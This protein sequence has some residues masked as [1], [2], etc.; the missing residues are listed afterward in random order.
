M[1]LLLLLLLC[2]APLSSMSQNAVGSWS[3]T[4]TTPAGNLKIV[5][6]ISQSDTIYS[7]TM[8]S[9][10]QRARD[11]PMK[12]TIVTDSVVTLRLGNIEYT[13]TLKRD[14]LRGT[15]TQGSF[16]TE[17]N[18]IRA[19]RPA[20]RPAEPKRPQE[21]K[22]PFDYDS[23]QVTFRNGDIELSGT[24][25]TP[26]GKG[27]SMAVVMVTGSGA[28]DRDEQI[29]G[30]KPFLVIADHLTRNG[31]SVLRYDDRGVGGSTGSM[32]NS[33]TSDFAIDVSCA[34]QFLKTQPEIDPRRIGII[35]NSEGGLIAPM[36]ASESSDV[37]F[38]VLL[39]APAMRGDKL[40]LLQKR[41]IEQA[42]GYNPIQVELSS[43]LMAGAFALINANAEPIT[44]SLTTYF[45][46]KIPTPQLKGIVAQLSST[47]FV[48][49]VRTDPAPYLSRVKCPILALN[50]GK[51]LQVPPTE[52]ITLIKEITSKAGNSNVTTHIMPKL[53]HL[54]QECTTGLPSE[55]AQIEQT[56]HPSVL[57]TMS[58]WILQQK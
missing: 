30:H 49:L 55:Y 16:K 24:L 40:I 44:D 53:N 22:P 11:I 42:M 37:A 26:R 39:A 47:W 32:T 8:D 57:D 5:F 21:P 19:E 41:F 34:I 36:V 43:Q 27:R 10:D 14:E 31:I 58:Q 17:L 12:T 45:T 46:G 52:N 2:L 13:G 23:K 35:G 48:N 33:T 56:I 25:T 18:L 50:G 3:G 28:Q 29:M 38:I 1:R 54:F 4:L 51:D 7:S 6:N 20:E 9:P 15:F